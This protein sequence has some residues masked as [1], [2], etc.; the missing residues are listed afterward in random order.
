MAVSVASVSDDLLV[1]DSRKRETRRWRTGLDEVARKGQKT[2]IKQLF[3]FWEELKNCNAQRSAPGVFQVSNAKDS[4]VQE[5]FRPYAE[6]RPSAAPPPTYE[7]SLS[8]LPPDYSSTDALATVGVFACTT[9]LASGGKQDSKQIARS[10]P[11][12]ISADLDISKIEGIREH[13][14]KKAKQA[15]KKTQQSKWADDGDGENPDG[16]A[17]GGEGDQTGGGDGGAGA[18]AGG[19]GGDP[20]GGGDGGGDDDLWNTGGGNKKK[21]KK[22]KKNAW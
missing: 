15:A 8:D 18:G 7:E 5:L 20:P 4:I 12:E 1:C 10:G 22:K 13:A 17:A 6:V 21:D 19:D 9:D 14:N 11:F 2:W 3:G 16:G